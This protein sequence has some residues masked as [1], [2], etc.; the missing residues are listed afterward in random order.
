M[1]TTYPLSRSV[2]PAAGSCEYADERRDTPACGIATAQSR[3]PSFARR[4]GAVTGAAAP[5]TG[6]AA[7]ARPAVP[8]PAADAS[9]RLQGRPDRQ[10]RRSEAGWAC[11]GNKRQ[12][13]WRS[14]EHSRR[15]DSATTGIRRPACGHAADSSRA[16]SGWCRR[17]SRQRKA[18]YGA[19]SH[20]AVLPAPTRVGVTRVP[21]AM[22]KGGRQRLQVIDGHRAAFAVQRHRERLFVGAGGPLG[23]RQC[24]EPRC[25]RVVRAQR[26]VTVR[27]GVCVGVVPA[28]PVSARH[29]RL[30]RTGRPADPQHVRQG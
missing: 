11:T 27:P 17:S 12:S 20:T 8:A 2:A 5:P 18:L 24:L 9:P 6:T 3:R 25:G 1:R 28:Q 10:Q 22:I 16:P 29:R 21:S 14:S 7:R 4:P 30:T 19:V 26:A 13:E 23:R 15:S